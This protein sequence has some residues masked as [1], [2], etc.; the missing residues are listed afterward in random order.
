MCIF[1]HI[2]VFEKKVRKKNSFAL[3]LNKEIVLHRN[4]QILQKNLV[5]KIKLS[6]LKYQKYILKLIILLIIMILRNSFKNTGSTLLK[7][8]MCLC[9]RTCHSSCLN[10]LDSDFATHFN[11]PENRFQLPDYLITCSSS[12]AWLGACLVVSLTMLS[13]LQS[14]PAV[15]AS[16]LPFIRSSWPCSDCPNGNIL[17]EISHDH[18]PLSLL[19]RKRF[20]RSQH[21]VCVLEN[22]IWMSEQNE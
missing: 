10:T 15:F 6:K 5:I 2:Y 7:S 19:G 18:H 20:T 22:A 11:S 12:P 8:T 16:K 21:H 13:H 4:F 9:W 1:S 14:T 3:F 17:K